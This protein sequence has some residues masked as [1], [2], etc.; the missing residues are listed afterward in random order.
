MEASL[1]PSVPEDVPDTLEVVQRTG[2][3]GDL[4]FL[5]NRTNRPL[6][7]SWPGGVGRDVYR[8]EPRVDRLSFCPYGVRVLLHG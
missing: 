8:D 7:I 5:L 3:N 4:L 6:E 2:P 1:E